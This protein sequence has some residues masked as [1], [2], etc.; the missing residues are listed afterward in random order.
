ML[1]NSLVNFAANCGPLSDTMLSG[2]PFNF[3]T[4][5][6]NSLAN[7]SVDIPSIVATKY[8]IFDS[9]SQITRITFFPATN[10]HFVMKSTIKY[11]YGF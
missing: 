8:V 10:S 5:S 3:Y 1:F 2:N 7:P 9:L 4:L 11:V 6:L